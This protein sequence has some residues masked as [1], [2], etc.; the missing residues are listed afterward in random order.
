MSSPLAPRR[1]TRRAARPPA[2][3][4]ALAALSLL[5]VLLLAMPAG[6]PASVTGRHGASTA[7]RGGC[8]ATTKSQSRRQRR[9]AKRLCAKHHARKHAA[10]KPKKTARKTA[11]APVELVPA[12]CEDGTLPSH[13]GGGTYSCED[14]SAPACEEGTL[15][16]GAATT[17]PMCAVKSSGELECSREPNG[18][19]ATIEFACEDASDSE[20]SGNCERPS[21]QEA[22]EEEE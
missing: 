22:P 19:C 3:L 10:H 16:R 9:A 21:E 13:A 8:P 11:A 17:A 2:L 5:L 1:P 4:A 15:V 12:A 7:A 18:E 20:M 6:A 14:G